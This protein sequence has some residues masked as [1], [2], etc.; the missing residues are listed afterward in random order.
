MLVEAALRKIETGTT[1]GIYLAF[2][3]Y[4]YVR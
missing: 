2:I 4:G 1:L 3:G